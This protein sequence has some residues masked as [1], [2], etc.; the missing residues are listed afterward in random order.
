MDDF[1]VPCIK[2]NRD[3]RWIKIITKK[4]SI[5]SPASRLFVIVMDDARNGRTVLTK[6]GS[7]YSC[8][9][10]IKKY[11]KSFSFKKSKYEFVTCCNAY[12]QECGGVCCKRLRIQEGRSECSC[13]AL[14]QSVK[15]LNNCYDD[16][17]KV[18]RYSS[19]RKFYISW[20]FK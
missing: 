12:P 6:G 20:C 14:P 8:A 17:C 1:N 10:F 19:K 11:H 15:H 18:F 7:Y 2:S 3:K 16:C 9:R 5:V 13:E 4:G